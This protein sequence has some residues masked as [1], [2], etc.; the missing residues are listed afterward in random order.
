M[1]NLLFVYNIVLTIFFTIDFTGFYVIYMKNRKREFLFLALLYL[2]LIIDNSLIYISEFSYSFQLLYETSTIVHIIIDLIYFGIILTARLIILEIFNDKFTIRE[3]YICILIPIILS[4]LSIFASYEISD[5]LIFIS[6]FIALSYIGFKSYKN[7]N[8]NPNIFNEKTSKKYKLFILTI[9]M[10]NILGIIESSIYYIKYFNNS[11]LY[12]IA[13]ESRFISFDIIK[14][15][16][17]II[18]IKNLYSSFERLFD[19][20]SIGDKLNDFCIKYSLTNRQR[21]IIELI[22]DGYSNKEIS[23]TLHI[24]EGT[25]KTHIYNIFKKTDISSRNQLLKK[26]I[27]D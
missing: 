21:E 16:I 7:I 8:N 13:L 11:Y 10:L 12:L 25:V 20:K 2:L 15:L 23:N 18:G 27:H 17:C 9:I 3:K 1:D 22:I 4:I 14:L 19:K 26:I 24:T 6:F 5:G